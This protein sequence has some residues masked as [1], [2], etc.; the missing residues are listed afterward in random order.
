MDSDAACFELRLAIASTV[1]ATAIA[2]SENLVP[3]SVPSIAIAADWT[4]F[5]FAIA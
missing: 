1:V 5:C 4:C 2:A 3:A